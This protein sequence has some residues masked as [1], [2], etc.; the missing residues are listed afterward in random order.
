MCFGCRF[1]VCV[2]LWYVCMHIYG[3]NRY[4]CG[5]DPLDSCVYRAL[6]R[7]CRALLMYISVGCEDG[8]CA[9]N[10]VYSA[11]VYMHVYMCL[12][13][14]VFNK[15]LCMCLWNMR[16]FVCRHV[17]KFICIYI[18]MRGLWRLQSFGCSCLCRRRLCCSGCIGYMC[19]YMY[20]YVWMYIYLYVVVCIHNMWVCLEIHICACTY[21]YIYA[22]TFIDVYIYMYTYINIYIIYIYI[23]IYT[24]KYR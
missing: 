5:W 20:L 11:Y 13:V 23:Y 22:Y 9:N 18:C 16:I 4:A 6:F 10:V 3:K 24:C 14:Y 17:C 21:I 19:I 15:Y 12:W 1:F 8:V 2:C 7:I